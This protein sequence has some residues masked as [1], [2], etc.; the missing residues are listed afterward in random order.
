[1]TLELIAEQARLDE[2]VRLIERYPALLRMHEDSLRGNIISLP[3]IRIREIIADR[4]FMERSADR[5]LTTRIREDTEGGC[6][7]FLSGHEY[8]CSK[9]EEC[10]A[11]SPDDQTLR[12]MR[13]PDPG[14]EPDV[15][16]PEELLEGLAGEPAYLIWIMSFDWYSPPTEE[17]RARGA[18]R[19]DHV[20]WEMDYTIILPPEGGFGP[21]T[22]AAA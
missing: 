11:I 2:Q 20:C 13:E 12:S 17:V 7:G 21:L 9:N 22:S 5:S 4:A 19:G 18:T 14:K 15:R 6:S 8:V 16:T 1:M 10:H 3:H